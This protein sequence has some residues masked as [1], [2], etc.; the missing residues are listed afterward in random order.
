M[1]SDI[2]SLISPDN[3]ILP[4]AS[5][6]VLQTWQQLES[7]FS[8]FDLS[9]YMVTIT[10]TVEITLLIKKVILSEKATHFSQ[11]TINRLASIMF[12][13]PK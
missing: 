13:E 3:E 6:F 2:P 5:L 7:R 11:A 12:Q 8:L 4:T 1:I 9:L 10:L